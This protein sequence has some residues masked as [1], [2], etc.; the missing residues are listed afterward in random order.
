MIQEYQI[1]ILPEQAASE[2]G[3]KRYLA[4]E[5]GLDVRT[6]NQV[7]VLKRSIDARQRT[8][9]VNLKVRAYINEFPQDD[10]Y[11][12]TKYP[13]VSS[14]PRV[15]VVG[16]GPGGLFASLR[17]IE[18][19]YRPIVLERGKDVRER[20]KDLSN[21]TKTQKVDGESNYCFGEGGAGAYSDGK[22]Y[23][24]SKKRG[25]VDKILNVFCQHGANT[26]ILAD[27]HPHIGTDKLP[28]VIEN[29]RNTI[30]KCGGEVH[31]QTKMI[32]LIL[33]SEGKLTAPDAAAGDRVIGVEA[34]NLATGAEETYRG[35]VILATGHS[36]RDVYRYLASAKIDIEAKGIA[37]GVRL[38]H[39]SQL[40]DQIQY[41]NKSGRGK[42]L[43]AAEYSFVT[44]VDG[45]GVYSFCMCPGGFVIPAAT[46]PEQLVVNGMSPSNR[47]TAWSNSGMVVETHPEDV[48]QFVKEHQSV[49]EQQEMKAQENASL[50]TPHSSLQM[51]YFQEIVEKQCWQQGNMK[52]TAPAQRMADFVNNR[53]SYDLPKSSYAPGLISS[54]LH[55]WMP[56]FVSK[57]LQEGF[58]TFGKNAHGF[59]TN[60]ATLIAMETRTSSPVRIVRD[61]ETLQH[62]RIQGLFPCGEGAG[63]AGGIVSAGVDGERCAEMCAEYLKQQ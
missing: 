23:T 13:D 58:K 39:P 6:L 47:G 26:N 32:R 24:R 36:A 17:L 50:F 22:L 10:Q 20:K 12:H 43:P 59:L 55:F 44:Q 41:H 8:I 19:G 16:E 61:R 48:A 33:E 60:E 3:I 37:V 57:R 9:F 18:L 2:E 63:Y 25:S 29:M 54:P 40:I 46:G 21:I 5:K 51:M 49:I 15:I 1:R 42:Y 52:Q 11:I 38:E 62:I 4:K 30:I 53:L 28:R 27:A 45:R 7:R 14:R 31:F 34:V 35:P 56:S